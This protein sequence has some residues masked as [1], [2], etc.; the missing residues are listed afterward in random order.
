MAGGDSVN[1]TANGVEYAVTKKISSSWNYYNKRI[2]QTMLEKFG[3][4]FLDC[5]GQPFEDDFLIDEIL[6]DQK[7]RMKDEK[8]NRRSFR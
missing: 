7:E 5:F 3:K 1:I 6:E 2:A 8:N 4:I